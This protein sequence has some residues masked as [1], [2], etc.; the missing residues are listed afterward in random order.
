MANM[1][2]LTVVLMLLALPASAEQV[3]RWLDAQGNVNFSDQPPPPSAKN[4]SEK[5]Y[6]SN[7][8]EGH[9]TPEMLQAKLSNP[10]TLY[11]SPTCGTP[12]DRVKAHLARRNIP[13]SSKDPS[14]DKNAE[15]A[16][17]K[18]DGKILVPTLVVGNEKIEGYAES[19]LDAALDKA[20][21]PPPSVAVR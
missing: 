8:I 18:P 15:A 1:K 14:S 10:V 21:Y 5:S 6:K 13:Y 3:Y 4:A 2:T 9:I 12:C 17:R 19:E 20:G 16:I 7:S 11:A